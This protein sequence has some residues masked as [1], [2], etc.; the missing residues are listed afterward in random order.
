LMVS[1][2]SPC[3]SF[4]PERLH[5]CYIDFHYSYMYRYYNS[6]W[7]LCIKCWDLAFPPEI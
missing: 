4:F 1:W 5:C 2:V 7:T 3:L 6:S